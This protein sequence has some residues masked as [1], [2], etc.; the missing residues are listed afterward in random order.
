MLVAAAGVVAATGSL[1]T[2]ASTLWRAGFVAVDLTGEDGED[3]Y[4]DD[5][6][7]ALRVWVEQEWE[8]IIEATNSRGLRLAAEGEIL[9]T[10]P[11]TAALALEAQLKRLAEPAE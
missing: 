9:D 11:K 4:F 8:R 2:V 6:E 7:E 1:D 3:L 10:D 5:E